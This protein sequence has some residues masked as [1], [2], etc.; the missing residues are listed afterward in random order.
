MSHTT[1]LITMRFLKVWDYGVW[2]FIEW[3]VLTV[4]VIFPLFRSL[5]QE[6]SQ[7]TTGRI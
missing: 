7:T 2:T 4:S 5:T 6:V 3:N 1:S